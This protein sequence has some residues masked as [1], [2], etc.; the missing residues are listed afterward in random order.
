MTPDVS[1]ALTPVMVWLFNRSV[2]REPGPAGREAGKRELRHRLDVQQALLD[3]G[4]AA[5]S[6]EALPKWVRDLH[7]EIMSGKAL[8][9]VPE[10][11]EMRALGVQDQDGEV[12]A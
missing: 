12:T 9:S 11:A 7:T 6:A 5:P 2:P 4:K 1:H 3:I 8:A 10:P